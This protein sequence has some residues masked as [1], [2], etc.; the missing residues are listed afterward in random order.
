MVR[1]EAV[2]SVVLEGADVDI[3]D[4]FQSQELADSGPTRKDVQEALTYERTI[5]EGA[6]QLSTGDQITLGLLRDLHEL[7]MAD[8]RGHCEYLG[9][10]RPKPINL[11]AASSF[12]EPFVLPAPDKTPEL[13]TNLIEYCNTTSE[14]HDL[15]Q[16]GFVHYQF[17][18]RHPFEDGN[19][20]LGRI[21][22]TLQLIQNGEFE[23]QN[24]L[25]EKPG[26]SGIKS[27]RLSTSS[28]F[29]TSRWSRNNTGLP[30]TVTTVPGG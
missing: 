28:P 19:G 25:T 26:R 11:P 18:T 17:E 7:L 2:E 14:Y 1:R 6:T 13:M 4:E 10:F 24:V 30:L 20:R 9:E 3:E 8:V 5:T 22:I 15:V 27:S 29:S 23:A 21:L 12:Q 16:F